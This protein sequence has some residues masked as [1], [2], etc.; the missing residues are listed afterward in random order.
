MIEKNDTQGEVRILTLEGMRDLVT[1]QQALPE[2]V[3]PEG[4][5]GPERLDDSSE[6]LL[7]AAVRHGMNGNQ[8]RRAALALAK[9]DG[10][11]V[12]VAYTA[13][14]LQYQSMTMGQ[15]LD[16]IRKAKQFP[17]D[18]DTVDQAKRI[19]IAEPRLA[20]AEIALPGGAT[21]ETG[22]VVTGFRARVEQA[23]NVYRRRQASLGLPVSSLTIEDIRRSGKVP[24]SYANR[25]RRLLATSIDDTLRPAE[26]AA[27][28]LAPREIALRIM[29]HLKEVRSK[30][31]PEVW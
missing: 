27:G 8:A 21:K 28:P 16:V 17:D 20:E 15:K 11:D 14:A 24:P 1:G 25:G 3:V 30:G 22:V 10:R 26:R 23:E 9:A 2:R 19:Q 13:E 5:A 12:S 4:L 7:Q 29:E 6:G 31:G 18:L